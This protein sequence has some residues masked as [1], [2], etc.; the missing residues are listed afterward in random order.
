M[1]N[2]RKSNAKK[3]F[4]GTVRDDRAAR[5]AGEQLQK[6]PPPPDH[7]SV[8]AAIQWKRVAP[9]IHALGTLRLADL[10]AL[11]LLCST[12]STAADAAAVVEREGMTISTD[13][14]GVKTH[15][16][17][18]L[19]EVARAQAQRLLVEFGL[20][21]RSR[22][23]VDTAPAPGES[24]RPWKDPLKKFLPWFQNRQNI[25]RYPPLVG[26]FS[27]ASPRGLSRKAYSGRSIN[28]PCA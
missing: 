16:A 18:K 28:W 10:T 6:S 24:R 15:P 19:L 21:P 13:S 3:H 8:G 5:L 2:A 1:P 25:T 26:G 20:S 17:V 7:L 23:S 14:G 12:L 9:T 22:G 11:E 4:L 27:I